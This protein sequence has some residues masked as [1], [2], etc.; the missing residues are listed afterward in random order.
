MKHRHRRFLSFVLLPALLLNIVISCIA[1]TVIQ[2]QAALAHAYVIGSDPVDGSTVSKVPSVVRIFFNTAISSIS[3]ANVSYVQNGAFVPTQTRS[4]V[5]PNNP[6]ELDTYL[7]SSLLQGSYFV[8]WTA[9]SNDDGH[10]TWG[11]IGFDVGRSSTG[12]SGQPTLGPGSSNDLD[13]VR[14]LDL[15]GILAVAWEWLV[16]LALTFW[17][18][19]LVTE[20][21]ILTRTERAGELLDR[22]RKQAVPLQ[23]LCLSSLLVGEFVALILRSVHIT[24]A[25][26]DGTLD[27]SALGLLLDETTYGRLWLLRTLLIVGAL[28]LLWWTTRAQ[29]ELSEQ[30]QPR[31]T[32]SGPLRSLHDYSTPGT[33]SAVKAVIELDNA[34]ST[35]SSLQRYTVPWLLLA[36]LIVCTYA[37]TGS[38]AQV[39][40]TR[41]SAVVFDGLSL[42]AQCIWFGGLAYLGYVLLPLLQ[43]IDLDSNTEMLLAF[44][45]RLTPFIIASIGVQAV[46]LLFLSEAT[47]SAPQLLLTDPYGRA[48]LVKLVLVAI[49]LLVSIYALF[50]LRPKLA[51]QAI[52]LPV[53]DAE[54]PARRARQSALEQ[55]IRRLKAAASTQALL[56][57]G[58]LLCSALMAFYAPPIV[59]PNISY[60]NPPAATSTTTTTQTQQVGN[61]SVT[62]QILPGRVNTTNTVIIA[63]ADASDKP[64]TDAKVRLHT[65]MQAMDM[66]TALVNATGGNP[67]YTATFDKSEA[68]SMSGQWDI[69][70]NIQR[71]GQAPAQTTFQ[72]T[73]GS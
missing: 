15:L 4:A 59:F 47:I 25:L 3:V 38:A 10:T 32:H 56:G 71:P 62:L 36:G 44:L 50:M 20:R 41:A 28:T 33:T 63:I 73:V 45:R 66:G 60:A 21:L 37:L 17:I 35:P 16:L 18:G 2:P 54:L 51:R 22:A 70:V 11:S 72:V 8:R 23:W 48:L 42:L 5:S 27:L 39:A 1:A 6:R 52:L 30:A 19:L 40:Q 58:V 9:V 13:K 57:A 31:A 34:L 29:R 65:N 67:A 24:R 55:T 68:F 61:L 7:S 14:N 69:G 46:S 26:N 43:S 49:I 12:V 53:V 64:V